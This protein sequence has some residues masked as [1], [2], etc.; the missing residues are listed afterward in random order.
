[1][2]E[3]GMGTVRSIYSFFLLACQLFLVEDHMF[4]CNRVIFTE[5]KLL[6]LFLWVLLLNEEISSASAAYQAN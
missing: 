3:G 6:S 4:S 1:M 2:G 5:G